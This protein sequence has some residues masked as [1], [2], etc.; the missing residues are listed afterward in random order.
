M[1]KLRLD[2]GRIYRHSCG[3]IPVLAG[4]GFSPTEAVAGAKPPS[5]SRR[6]PDGDLRGQAPWPASDHEG[7][8]GA[9]WQTRRR[10]TH[11]HE[12]RDA[13]LESSGCV[14]VATTGNPEDMASR[15]LF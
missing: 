12:V 15:I 7:A 4:V 3:D 5:C 14:G 11:R 10:V 9:C 13:R 8:R 1:L 6:R 2:L